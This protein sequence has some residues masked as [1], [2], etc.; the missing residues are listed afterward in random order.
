MITEIHSQTW[1]QEELKRYG[2]PS[3]Y[4]T[5]TRP[6]FRKDAPLHLGRDG[7]RHEVCRWGMETFV[8]PA[9]QHAFFLAWDAPD[10]GHRDNGRMNSRQHAH[11]LPRLELGTDLQLGELE[12]SWT[13]HWNNDPELRD[14]LKFPKVEAVAKFYDHSQSR[15]Y[16]LDHHE[17]WDA[18]LCSQARPCRRGCWFRENTSSI[19]GWNYRN[20]QPKHARLAS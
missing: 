19:N 15:K 6:S 14:C 13:D 8:K 18:C 16:F 4:I 9:K 7:F 1:K 12:Q 10:G 11:I 2:T 5:L 3:F 20:G 17:V